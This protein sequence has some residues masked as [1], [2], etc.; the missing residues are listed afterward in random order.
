MDELCKLLPGKTSGSI[1]KRLTNLRYT[2]YTDEEDEILKAGIKERKKLA[3]LSELLPGRTEKS[4]LA[5][6]AFLKKILVSAKPK[7]ESNN[8][9]IK[10]ELIPFFKK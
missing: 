9:K 5:R 3:E 10:L 4:I 1:R 8:K 7:S 6:F 2:S